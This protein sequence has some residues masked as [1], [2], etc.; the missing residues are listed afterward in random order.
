MILIG[1]IGIAILLPIALVI[2][3]FPS[4]ASKQAGNIHTLYDVL[5]IATVPIFVL[6]ETVVLF[7]VWKFRMRPGE[8]EKD[9][10]PIHGNTRLEVVWTVLPACLILGLCA[11][12]YTV[13]HRNED[14]KQGELHVSVT[15]RQFG[16]EF[17]YP[18]LDGKNVV[19]PVLYLPDH[20]AIRFQ[21]RSLDVI[22]SFFVPEFSEKI[23]A[24]PGITTTIRV[25]TTRLGTYPAECTELCGAGHSL[26][27]APVHVVTKAAFAAWASAQATNTPPPLGTPPPNAAESGEPGAPAGSPSSSNGNVKAGAASSGAATTTAPSSAPATS[28]AAAGRTVFTQTASPTCSTCHTLAAAGASGTIGPNLDARLRSDCAT[29]A[30]KRIRGATLQQCIYT[31][32]TNPYKYLP[33]GYQAGIMPSTFAKTLTGAQIQSLVAFLSSAAK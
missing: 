22:H 13:L 1:V 16:F 25:T 17:S 18:G 10:P 29:A 15:A 9:G 30:S 6:V 8:E 7:S 21:L 32:I 28:S 23:D 5:L 12:A 2:P 31:A 24:V 3:W 27:R 19:S 14:T 20:R 33:S 4:S 26:M 11:Y